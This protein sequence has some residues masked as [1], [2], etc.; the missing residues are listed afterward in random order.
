MQ[1]NHSRFSGR[2]GQLT[3]L[4]KSIKEESVS[5]GIRIFLETWTVSQ[6]HFSSFVTH[7]ISTLQGTHWWSTRMLMPPF[8]DSMNPSWNLH[9]SLYSRFT[10]SSRTPK[11]E[12]YSRFI[13]WIPGTQRLLGQVFPVKTP[14]GVAEAAAEHPQWEVDEPVDIS[15]GVNPYLKVLLN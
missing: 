1:V 2:R 5:N 9:P 15:T 7:D 3:L 4:R 6:E 8:C 14:T 13:L 12:R 11:L 10:F